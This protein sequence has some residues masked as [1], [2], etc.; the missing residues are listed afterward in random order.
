MS[1]SHDQDREWALV[2][3]IRALRES[4][5]QGTE[6]KAAQEE[7]VAAFSKDIRSMARKIRK[8]KG[9]S[10][11]FMVGLGDANEGALESHLGGWIIVRSVKTYDPQKNDSFKIWVVTNWQSKM[12][13]GEYIR[14]CQKGLLHRWERDENGKRI[15]KVLSVESL[16]IRL[17][18]NGGERGPPL[19]DSV[20]RDLGEADHETLDCRDALRSLAKGSSL[21]PGRMLEL[22]KPL[23]CPDCKTEETDEYRRRE[24]MLALVR[25][26]LSCPDCSD[27]FQRRQWWNGLVD[28]SE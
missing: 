6:L 25:D 18:N 17:E 4:D 20:Q 13:I 3:R 22:L 15:R 7:L 14:E 28:G 12:C 9:F 26:D 24:A 19:I 23:A 27:E 1:P 8:T 5:P 10:S 21:M 2:Q 16:D 11:V